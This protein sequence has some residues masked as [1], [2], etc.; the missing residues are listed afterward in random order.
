[1][2][3]SPFPHPCPIAELHCVS[4][5]SFLRGASHPEELVERAV[6]LGYAALAITDECSLA[7]IVRAHVRAREIAESPTGNGVG[8][9]L[10]V[11]T[12]LALGDGFR[13][14][15]LARD[16]AGYRA[17]CALITAARRAAPKG[18]YALDDALVENA[19]LACCALL[20]VPP[21]LPWER[22][23]VEHRFGW[24]RALGPHV[25]LALEL[26]H[27]PYDTKHRHWLLEVSLSHALPLVAA[28]DVHQHERSRRALQ[29][30]L[31]CI[32]HGCT[33]DEA[34]GRLLPNGERHLRH[35]DTLR[36]L[37]PE[38]TLREAARVAA[39]CTFSLG[40]LRYRY[41]REVVPAG[42]TPA[43]H[44]ARLVDDGARERWPDGCPKEVRHRLDEELALI[45][46]LDYESYF[47]TVHDVVRFARE[48]GILCQGRGSA[49]NSAVCYS[50]GVTAVNPASTRLLFG[51]FLSRERNEPPDIDI[52]FE[53]E[54]REEV[55]QYVYRKYGRHRAALA[56]TVI[57]YR[58]RSAVRD[59]GKAMGFS[60]ERV[61]ALSKSLAW[62]D[63][64]AAV[65]ERLVELGLDPEAPLVRR[66]LWLLP[67]LAGFPRHLSQHVGG[68]VI[69]DD[70]LVT[71][72]PV[73]NAAMPDRTIVQWEKD[74]LEALGL[75]KVD[76][77]AL[78]MLT[79]VRKCFELIERVRGVRWS[80][81][82]VPQ[83]DAATYD[84]ICR[85]DTVGA[86]QVES[87]AQMAMLPK[88]RPRTYYDLV[89]EISL[90]RPGPI[91][92]GMVS[93]YLARR[94]DPE[95]VDYPDEALRPILE[96][97]LGVPVFQ[98]QV[99]EIVMVAAGFSPGEADRLRRGMAAWKK[100]GEM[101]RF[102][103]P[104]VDGM[105]AKGYE[106]DFAERLFGQIEGFGEYGF[107]ESHA[108]SFALLVYVS[109]WLKC[110]EP[111]AFLCALLN[112]QPLGFYSPS[113]LVQDARR[114]GVA[115][116]PVDVN[117]SVA[118]HRLVVPGSPARGTR[119]QGS[120][121]S[122]PGTPRSPTTRS[123]PASLTGAN[124]RRSD[125]EVPDDPVGRTV[126]AARRALGPKGQPAVRL[127]FRLVAGLSVTG[128]A[129][130]LAAREQAPFRDVEDLVAR[131]DI[132]AKDRR[133]L[134]DAGALANLAGDRHHAQWA[135]LGVEDL[136]GLLR[137]ASAEEP[138][139][140]F[141]LPTEG[142]DIV[143]DYRSL[144]LTL[145]RHPLALLRTRLAA[146]R[147]IDSRSWLGVPDGRPARLAGLVRM[148]QRPGSAKGTMF[149]T[150]EDEGGSINVI[151]WPGVVD[152]YR[153]EVLGS[154]MLAVDGT[155]QRDSGVTHL[156]AGRC[157]DL[158]W[159]LGELDGPRSRDFH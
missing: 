65:P 127:G 150:L 40:S 152:R 83:D 135:L 148:R 70:D 49:A 39:G 82:T 73:E 64:M 78:G 33:L 87:R 88:L 41:P 48:R 23:A 62:W 25:Y 92:G 140:Q 69:S 63:G 122:P 151:L 12:E 38:E 30:V 81:A 24:A 144:G 131:S 136:P 91:Q 97:T 21:Y 61:E 157:E 149:L 90:V 10:I 141:E 66:F 20:L 118:D 89:I 120:P 147:V 98:E 35:P 7:G 137:G 5:F 158:S 125:G 94:Q 138:P 15:A 4:N 76:L 26:H 116:L 133:A 101:E 139:L 75:M 6:E 11:G 123:V 108:A 43:A 134:A 96:R 44:L 37:Y 16:A 45:R 109:C 80:M 17:I 159:M 99:M 156:V 143:A 36:A 56:A 29:D 53:H 28:G 27:G 126:A 46:E 1:M 110:H 114:H 95:L 18:E 60:L 59:L 42:L 154:R 115:V 153:Q 107:P 86:F 71:L 74:D 102:R 104:V 13:L 103:A 67:Q 50:L 111:A 72:V 19:G 79:A 146:R 117:R 68:F 130:L 14:V 106:R 124:D 100:S 57:R 93:P 51:R 77:L 128:T 32:R 145:G 132:D 8:L 34:G 105:L 84:M 22:E 55:I 58:S 52:D 2:A 9:R 54:R 155:T 85:A 31:A 121:T 142:E 112:S 129:A 47:L 119:A 3:S 113:D